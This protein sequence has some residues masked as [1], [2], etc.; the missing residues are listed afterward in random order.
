MIAV[1]VT[2]AEKAAFEESQ[3][4]LDAEL[5]SFFYLR[6]LGMGVSR[7]VANQQAQQLAGAALAARAAI[8]AATAYE[9]VTDEVTE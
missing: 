4:I 7:D 9:L 8:A 1:K 6:W 3:G 2:A 5:E